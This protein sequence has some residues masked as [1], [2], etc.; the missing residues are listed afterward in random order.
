MKKFKIG[1]K[2]GGNEA[3]RKLEMSFFAFK[4]RL[5]SEVELRLRISYSGHL[6]SFL[7]A[8]LSLLHFKCKPCLVKKGLNHENILPQ[9]TKCQFFA[10]NQAEGEKG[11]IPLW[12]M[13]HGEGDAPD[14]GRREGTSGPSGAGCLLWILTIEGWYHDHRP[15]SN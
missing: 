15:S 9:V 13:E 3:A 1:S 10:P 7:D 8:L 2:K 6:F 4:R 12:A 14:M 11:V 5:F